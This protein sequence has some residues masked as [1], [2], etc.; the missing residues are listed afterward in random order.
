[1]KEKKKHNEADNGRIENPW[2]IYIYIYIVA[3]SIYKIRV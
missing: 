1:M 2:F 3:K